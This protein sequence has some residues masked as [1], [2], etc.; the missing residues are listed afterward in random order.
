MTEL[1][2]KCSYG[3]VSLE[4]SK[5]LCCGE[6]CRTLVGKSAFFPASILCI[7]IFLMRDVTLDDDSD[8]E[9]RLMNIHAD[10]DVGMAGRGT[11]GVH[12]A[13]NLSEVDDM[14]WAAR[15]MKC[16]GDIDEICKAN[17]YISHCWD[18]DRTDVRPPTKQN[19]FPSGRAGTR[20]TV[21]HQNTEKWCVLRT[22]SRVSHTRSLLLFRILNQSTF[23]HRVL[24]GGIP[25]TAPISWSDACLPSRSCKP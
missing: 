8:Y 25:A 18:Y 7:Y 4:V 15:Y 19:V 22:S 3:R 9:A 12:L 11:F 5:C 20:T 14:P 17:K 6:Y 23:S 1:L 16:D 24:K 13:Q 10:V 21:H 2:S